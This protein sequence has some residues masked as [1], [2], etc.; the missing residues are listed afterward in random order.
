MVIAEKSRYLDCIRNLRKPHVIV[1]DLEKGK[2]DID[3][4]LPFP[5]KDFY[6]L[7]SFN[8]KKYFTKLEHI[9]EQYIPARNFSLW[10]VYYKYRPT[11]L[12]FD[13]VPPF[14]G[15]SVLVYWRLE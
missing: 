10:D 12:S 8:V 6:R 13:Q 14:T 15:K 11:G 3:F 2:I 7:P 9:A 1:F 4:Y 5:M